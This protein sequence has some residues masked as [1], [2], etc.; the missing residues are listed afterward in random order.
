M[1]QPLGRPA[2][3]PGLADTPCRQK[4]AS[5]I[6]ILVAVLVLSLGLLGLAGMHLRSLRASLSSEQ[7]TQAVFLGQYLMELMRVDKASA[8]QGAYNTSGG[9][10]TPVCTPPA[11]P[12]ANFAQAE[13]RQ[14]MLAAKASIGPQNPGKTCAAVDCNSAG[15]CT[16][17]LQWDDS[18]GGGL[19]EQSITLTSGL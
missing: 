18:L 19:S 3:L 17:R 12:T 16:V 13:L 7:R 9:T 15:L 2:K 1:P 6:E 11:L 8:L 14:W 4:G 5:L 10:A